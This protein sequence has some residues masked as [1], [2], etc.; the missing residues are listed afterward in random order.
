MPEPATAITVGGSI[1]GGVMAKEG[2]EDAADTAADSQGT[3]LA[4]EQQR[5]NDWKA[6]YG[7]IEANLAEYY[8]NLTPNRYITSNNEAYDK[9]YS[10]AKDRIRE[11]FT[12]RGIRPDSGVAAAVDAGMEINRAEARAEIAATAEQEVADRKQAFLGLGVQRDPS[13]SL[14]SANR[15][16]YQN[17]QAVAGQAAN[18][19]GRAV[20]QAIGNTTTA[21]ADYF[22][23]P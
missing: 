10:S 9:E 21:L 8:E 13:N 7:D 22:R 1:A 3:M 4:F 12:Q 16:V 17:D 5:Y 11:S 6:T 20:G 15:S 18:A 14:S 2:A 23:G 19:A